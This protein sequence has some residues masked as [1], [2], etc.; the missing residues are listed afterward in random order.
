MNANS[1]SK[2]LTA[3]FKKYLNKNISVNLIRH[4]F[5]SEYYKDTP[6]YTDMENLSEKMAHS[7]ETQQKIYVKK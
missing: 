2:F 4:I 5:L 3:I 6:K 1:L 7:I